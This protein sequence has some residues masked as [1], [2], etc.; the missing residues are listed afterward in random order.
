[1]LCLNGG[2][3][4]PNENVADFMKRCNEDNQNALDTSSVQKNPLYNNSILGIS[5]VL[6]L[7]ASLILITFLLLITA[8]IYVFREDVSLWAHSRYGIRLFNDSTNSS[9]SDA[10]F[11]EADRLYDAYMMYSCGDEEFVK[12][13][14]WPKLEQYGYSLCLHY[15]DIDDTGGT[16][17]LADSV[18]SAA[19]ASRRMIIYVSLNF[20]QNEWERPE[21]RASLQ[22]SLEQARMAQRRNKVI[23]LLTT[24]LE[25]LNL[26]PY[27]Q[28][29][30]KTS[31]VISWEDKKFWMK[32]RYAM[33]DVAV[34]KNIEMTTKLPSVAVNDLRK[35][36]GRD[37]E[38]VQSTSRVA[39]NR[40]LATPTSLDTWYKYSAIP[41]RQLP[42]ALVH[43]VQPTPTA[44][45][46]SFVSENSSQRTT[47]DH[48]EEEE[49][50]SATTSGSHQY[51]FSEH[52]DVR[53]YTRHHHRHLHLHRHKN[54]HRNHHYVYNTIPDSIPLTH[55]HSRMS[56]S[57]GEH[58]DSCPAAV[59][60]LNNVGSV[61]VNGQ[62]YFV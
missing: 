37:H 25:T 43:H 50:T 45:Q 21:L 32:L 8:I 31:K 12:I 61:V 30:M 57:G 60:K 10:D 41:P 35:N 22:A 23:F 51:E 6:L 20:L 26:D 3:K 53:G 29:Y 48:E 34:K 52:H 46:S 19:E 33:P 1:M 44:T 39:S 40:Y 4:K 49:E 54:N 18:L 2:N 36:V 9:S 16:T 47:A 27:L 7:A 17:Y 11:D 58:S 59:R 13:L 14:L 62:T 42:T 56:A 24:D 28:L 55:Q 5:Y 15:R 38:C